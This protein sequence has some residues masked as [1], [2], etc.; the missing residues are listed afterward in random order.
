METWN[1]C[2]YHEPEFIA[3][4]L[5]KRCLRSPVRRKYLLAFVIHLSL[6]H[7]NPVCQKVFNILCLENTP[8]TADSLSRNIHCGY[9]IFLNPSNLLPGFQ[10]RNFLRIGKKKFGGLRQNGKENPMML[11]IL[12]EITVVA[13]RMI[14]HDCRTP[15]CSAFQAKI[16]WRVHPMLGRLYR[17]PTEVIHKSR[18]LEISSCDNG[19]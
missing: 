9:R 12:P 7:Q 16:C 15:C 10:S 5:S 19:C 1:A 17:P 8:I 3:L 11:I 6:M 4:R 13:C 2:F 14:H 18:G